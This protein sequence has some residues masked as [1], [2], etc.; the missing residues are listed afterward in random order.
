MRGSTG[1][2]NI[3]T[4][5]CWISPHHDDIQHKLGFD[6]HYTT[7]LQTSPRFNDN[8]MNNDD[9]FFCF[10]NNSFALLRR[11]VPK[12]DW[13]D[14]QFLENRLSNSTLWRKFIVSHSFS[15]SAVQQL[16]HRV[17]PDFSFILFLFR[18]HIWGF[19]LTLMP[20]QLCRS[21]C[22]AA[23]VDHVSQRSDI[24]VTRPVI[25]ITWDP[26]HCTTLLGFHAAPGET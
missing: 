11:T 22:L 15:I 12:I 14:H 18:L 25:L 6:M 17:L 23:A 21:L 24:N 1:I 7:L 3:I 19:S 20:V 16:L 26:Y 4:A 13:T 9:D 5:S 8:T 2:L 10:F